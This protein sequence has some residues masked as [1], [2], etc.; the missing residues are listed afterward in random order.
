M[1]FTP[2][3]LKNF[4]VGV[5]LSLIAGMIA[6]FR[7]ENG[8][9]ILINIYYIYIK[10]IIVILIAIILTR[11]KLSP[12]LMMILYFV[13]MFY[14]AVSCCNDVAGRWISFLDL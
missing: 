3:T 8:D 9:I 11:L 7:I 13:I 10:N 2:I 1:D 5:I 4:F 12:L 14:N 6:T